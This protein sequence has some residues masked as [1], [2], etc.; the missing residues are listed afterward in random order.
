M[1]AFQSWHRPL[2]AKEL[3][4]LTLVGPCTYRFVVPMHAYVPESAR[5]V[6]MSAD[7]LVRLLHGH[8]VN[9]R[10]MGVVRSYLDP[11]SPVAA[12]I[13]EEMCARVVKNRIRD[14]M[15]HHGTGGV[16]VVVVVVVVGGGG[17]VFLFQF[18]L[19]VCDR[20]PVRV[21]FQ[22]LLASVHLRTC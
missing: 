1:R 11:Q 8:G 15:R 10:K 7:G 9:V 5:F 3:R 20:I 21:V 18:A 17:G 12:V 22:K 13:L 16:V 14:T 2:E 4:C 6:V 19:D